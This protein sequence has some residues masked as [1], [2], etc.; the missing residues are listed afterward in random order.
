MTLEDV[1]REH[2]RRLDA[3]ESQLAIGGGIATNPPATI[4][5]GRLRPTIYFPGARDPRAAAFTQSIDDALFVC[6]TWLRE[7]YKLRFWFEWTETRTSSIPEAEWAADLWGSAIRHVSPE[8]GRIDVVI[9]YC[10]GAPGWG[11]QL[12]NGQSGLATVNGSILER[13]ALT[14]VAERRFAPD[15]ALLNRTLAEDRL[16]S[17]GLLLH[18]ILHAAGCSVIDRDPNDGIYDAH[19]LD[20]GDIMNAAGLERF[21]AVTISASDLAILQASGFATEV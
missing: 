5:P 1:L 2:R 11:G 15:P 12:L 21:P 7:R 9:A 18:E 10:R 6:S 8:A 17:I 3:I 16:A 20:V 13:I 19:P 14:P 4:I